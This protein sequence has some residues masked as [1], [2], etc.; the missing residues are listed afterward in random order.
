MAA[1]LAL[2]VLLSGT[3]DDIGDASPSPSATALATPPPS[4]SAGAAPP[5]PS[6]AEPS[7]TSVPSPSDTPS[8]GVP[9]SWT[10]VATFSEAG[11]RYVFG[12]LTTRSGGGL[13]AVG[14]RWEEEFRSVFGPPPP[15]AG[16]VWT[17]SDGTTWTDVTPPGTFEDLELTHVYEAADGALVVIGDSWEGVEPTSVAWESTDGVTWQP[18]T[19]GGIPSN[20]RISGVA[21]GGRGWLATVSGNAY[22]SSD[23]RAWDPTLESVTTVAAGDEGFVAVIVREVSGEPGVAVVASSDGLTWFDAASPSGDA[24]G[25]A[26]HAGADWVAIGSAYGDGEITVTAWQSANGLDWTNSGAVPLA[27]VEVGGGTTCGE[28]PG[29][30]HSVGPLLLLGMTL[31]GPCSEGGVIGAGGSIAS[32]DGVTWSR[33]PFGDRASVVGAAAA[34]DGIVVVTDARTNSA[35][36]NGITFWV[37]TP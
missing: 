31:L 7:A 12:D 3:R 9:G 10:D 27:D 11:R 6:A 16:R 32:V 4:A 34:D 8:A 21:H 20:L 36:T 15:R 30:L 18:L 37:S 17:S 5:S 22:F 24:F 1:V 25:V 33:L 29:S 28:V 19:L 23:G 2:A 35:P 14:T 26:P 13:I